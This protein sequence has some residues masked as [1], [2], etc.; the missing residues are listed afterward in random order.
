MNQNDNIKKHDVFHSKIT[1]HVYDE[2][3]STL[4]NVG[5]ALK[6]LKDI[7]LLCLQKEKWYSKNISACR[8]GERN[9]WILCNYDFVDI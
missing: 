3:H 9:K 8:I 2:Q 4:G 1:A 6:L 7:A 5:G